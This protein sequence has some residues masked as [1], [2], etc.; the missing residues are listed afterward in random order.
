[1][2][3]QLHHKQKFEDL[4]YRLTNLD[5]LRRIANGGNSILFTYPPEEEKLYIKKAIELYSSKARFIDISK[6]FIEFIDKDGIDN[7]ITYYKDFINTPHV[8]FIAEDDPQDGLFDLIIYEIKKAL[9]ENKIPILIRTGCLYGTGIE[10]L[11]IMQNQNV[12]NKKLPL[13]VFYPSKVEDDVIKFLNFKNADKYR[14]TVI[15]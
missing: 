10:N 13:I 15:K 2:S 14:C 5:E 7:F 6:L 4:D 8:I 9:N 1:M 3:Y 12:M 11:K